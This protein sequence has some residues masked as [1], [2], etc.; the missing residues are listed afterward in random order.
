MGNKLFYMAIV[1]ILAAAVL[2]QVSYAR[3]KLERTAAEAGNFGSQRQA[4]ESDNKQLQAKAA[5]L[6]QQIAL[7]ENKLALFKMQSAHTASG[8]ASGAQETSTETIRPGNAPATNLSSDAR[9][10]KARSMGKLLAQIDTESMKRGEPSSEALRQMS[11]LMKIMADL[12]LPL[13]ED[14]EATL[15]S[16]LMPEMRQ[17]LTNILIGALEELK[18]PLNAVQASQYEQTLGKMAE[19]LKITSSEDFT[20]AEKAIAWLRNYD[21]ATALNKELTDIFT[22]RQTELLQKETLTEPFN[23]MPQLPSGYYYASISESNEPGKASNE[24]LENWAGNISGAS[25]EDKNILK[26]LS[27]QY[28]H[29][30]VVLRNTLEGRYGKT[31]MDLYLGRNKPGAD[32]LADKDK[33]KAY[34]DESRKARISPDY[35]KAKN[36]M[37]IEFLQ[38]ADRYNKEIL[39]HL[40]GEK[41]ATFKK[42]IPQI[43]HFANIN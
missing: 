11:E 24:V 7:L 2:I 40:D 28:V 39:S 25:E 9:L 21:T 38:V 32:I 34:Y 10:A 27:E 17:A 33:T 36:A 6:E 12:E 16:I 15:E 23:I 8:S 43:I 1:I 26:P 5:A 29:D 42:G 30:Y 4:L 37:D 41:T 13:H 14:Q 31:V 18:E 19:L 35:I 3:K 22:K 20:P